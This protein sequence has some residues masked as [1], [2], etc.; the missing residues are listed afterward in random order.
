[1]SVALAGKVVPGGTT[2][3]LPLST[4]HVPTVP[5]EAARI[6]QF[7]VCRSH[8][9]FLHYNLF[10][11][12]LSLSE[13]FDGIGNRFGYQN[14]LSLV[15]LNFTH[16]HTHTHIPSLQTTFIPSVFLRSIQS[17]P[18]TQN[19]SLTHPLT[20]NSLLSF[21]SGMQIVCVTQGRIAS[22]MHMGRPMG[23]LRVWLQDRDIPGLSMTRSF[24][25]NV[26]ASV[27]VISKPEVTEVSPLCP[28]TAS[29]GSH[30]KIS[31]YKIRAHSR[32]HTHT[33]KSTVLMTH[34]P[35]A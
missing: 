4:D 7:R 8:R 14:L 26:A 15:C 33:H 3:G 13:I 10:H 18:T 25:D 28:P 2:E 24:G 6:R 22:F 12:N 16:T 31:L 21:L 32:F 27:G 29:S 11:E 9:M 23:P 1:M 19:Y 20:E 34:R 35:C 5:S 17:S 30:S